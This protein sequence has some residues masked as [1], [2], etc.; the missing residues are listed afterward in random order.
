MAC[1]EA[2]QVTLTH[3]KIAIVDA[4]ATKL[5]QRKVMHCLNHTLI[6]M[7]GATGRPPVVLIAHQYDAATRTIIY[8]SIDITRPGIEGSPYVIDRQTIPEYRSFSRSVS[9][10]GSQQR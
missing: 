5:P 8:V 1:K 9:Q 7:A 10:T 3:L 6:S 2:F 4:G